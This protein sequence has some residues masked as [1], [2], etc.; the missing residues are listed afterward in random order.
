LTSF[1]LAIA[2][3]LPLEST[4]I[5]V[6]YPPSLPPHLPSFLH[7]HNHTST[8]NTTTHRIHQVSTRTDAFAYGIIVIE[9]LTGLSPTSARELVDESLFEELPELIRELCDERGG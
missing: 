8:T 3:T 9:V 1:D 5:S 2:A 7:H 6:G 4:N